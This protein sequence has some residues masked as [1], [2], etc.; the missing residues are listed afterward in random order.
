VQFPDTDDWKKL[1]HCLT[2]LRDEQHE[3]YTLAANG[4]WT[5]RWWIDASYAV[6]PD[7]KS[8]TGASMSLGQGCVYSML[9]K[10]KLNT[11]SSTEAELVAVNDAMSKILW[12]RL[13]LQAYRY[14]I[15]DNV[16]YQDN[17]SAILLEKNGKMSSSMKTR[18]I[19]IQFFFITD[20]VQKKHI[21]VEYCPTDNIGGDFLQSHYRDRNSR[22]LKGIS[23]D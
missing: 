13:F 14:Q 5:V 15:S 10:Q 12:T 1:G 6:H 20:N 2:Y 3:K 18:H 4:S 11:R 9:N 22:S 7:M 19:E 16:V 17:Q 21:Q 8:H 23:S